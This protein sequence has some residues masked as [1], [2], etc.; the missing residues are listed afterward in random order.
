[1]MSENDP[2]GRTEAGCDHS[3]FDLTHYQL[4]S[5]VGSKERKA[6]EELC[7]Q[8][9]SKLTAASLLI[10]FTV[11]SIYT[12]VT[13][14]VYAQGRI[15]YFIIAASFLLIRNPLFIIIIYLKSRGKIGAGIAKSL[16]VNISTVLSSIC[17]GLF[18]IGRVLNGPCY[19]EDFVQVW[20][21][22]PEH[23]SHALPQDVLFG[24]LFIPIIAS[25]IFKVVPLRT[26]MVTWFLA[27]FFV[28]LAIGVGNAKQSLPIL[29]F[30]IPLSLMVIYEN[31]RQDVILFLLSCKKHA[32]LAENMRLSE[33][34]QTELRFMIANLAHDLK[35]VSLFFCLY[36]NLI[37][38]L[39]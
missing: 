13:A 18:L 11:C 12:L 34:A 10:W 32:L 4:L 22:N 2:V 16:V 1:M 35:T 9:V 25:T 3:V 39:S 38:Y 20:S 7:Q 23:E 24:L 15:V 30:Y 17:L 29:V 33:E 36:I 27:I 6:Y 19:D 31:Y 37:I 5:S 26:V 14:L 28:C 21:C 8:R